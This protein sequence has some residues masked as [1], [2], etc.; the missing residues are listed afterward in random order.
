[1]AECLHPDA[2]NSGSFLNYL[3][4]QASE[5]RIP[6]YG[7]IELTKRCNLCC[8]HCYLGPQEVYHKNRHEELTTAQVT[9]IL[10]QITEAG[11]L[12]LLITGGDPLLRKDFAEI[13]THAK[14]SGLIVTVFTNGTLINDRVLDLFTE[15]P[16][17][18]VEV[19]VYGA[20]AETYERV[21]GNK[22][23]FQRCMDGIRAL[24]DRGINYNLKT[25]LMKP[26]QHELPALRKLADDMGVP[27]RFEAQISPTL[28]GDLSPIELRV[29]AHEAVR[30][31]FSDEVRNV[32]WVE[33]IDRLEP[34]PAG[35]TVYQCGAGQTLFHIDPTG[36]LQAC[37][38][39][40]RVSYDLKKG[41]F[42]TGWRDVISKIR[43][44]KPP[45]SYKCN[46][47]S[48]RYYCDSC[49]AFFELENGAN[50]LQSEYVCSMGHLRFEELTHRN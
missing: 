41:D 35:D 26:N 45:S 14:K 8:V 3:A 20:T 2:N 5:Q 37:L 38:M 32:Q 36:N 30:E 24:Q 43:E 21:T 49:P 25:V 12:Y 19:S 7:S 13:Y 27:F 11:C 50:N 48:K 40:E 22:G 29:P 47:C 44:F 15:L 31:E 46:E 42:E 10:D 17:R 39:T 16:P 4:A 1:M 6:I 33:F 34:A 28:E 9:S 18:V 23:S